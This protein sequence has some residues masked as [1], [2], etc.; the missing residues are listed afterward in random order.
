MASRIL[1]QVPA[2]SAPSRHFV[3]VSLS[4]WSG[5]LP[6]LNLIPIISCHLPPDNLVP[7]ISRRYVASCHWTTAIGVSDSG[8]VAKA[9][10]ILIASSLATAA[11]I[12]NHLRF[13]QFEQI[14]HFDQLDHFG[15]YETSVSR[16]T[17][18]GLSKGFMKDTLLLFV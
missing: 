13:H 6:P 4:Y 12:D 17:S 3:H 11:K 18:L 7:I 9:R 14:D 10:E 16:T 2:T 1:V 5:A 8:I 15:Q